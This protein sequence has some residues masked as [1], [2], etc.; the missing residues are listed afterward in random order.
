GNDTLTGGAGNDTFITSAGTDTIT[1]FASGDVVSLS[2]RHDL[3][4]QTIQDGMTTDGTNVTVDLGGG[5]TLVFADPDHALTHEDFGIAENGG[6]NT[7]IGGTGD[8]TL[9]G[10]TGNDTL[11]GAGG[12]DTLIGGDGTD[13]ADYADAAGGVTVDLSQTGGQTVGG[14][15]GIDTLSGIENLVGGSGN[16][17]LSGDANGNLLTG[18]DG[19]DTLSGGGGNDTLVSGAGYDIVDGGD[20]TDIA[21]FTGNAADYDVSIDGMTVMVK[22]GRGAA[23]LTDIETIRFDDAD[24]DVITRNL[25][26]GTGT[27]SMANT[28]SA[29]AVYNSRVAGLADGN[30]VVIWQDSYANNAADI[31]ARIF[32][33]DGNPQGSEFVVHVNGSHRENFPEITA[34]ENGGF[35]VAWRSSSTSDGDAVYSRSFDAS[36]SAT[37]ADILLHSATFSNSPSDLKLA[38]ASDGGY[39]VSY[40]RYPNTEIKKVTAAGSVSGFETNNGEFNADIALLENGNLAVVAFKS[41]SSGGS[42]T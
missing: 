19:H 38:A 5:D 9:D 21:V 20:G 41:Q 18:A 6:D 34:L 37:S 2:D 35:A 29:A 25:A 28:T 17:R 39:F 7:F 10:G 13:T 8:D 23:T 32:D 11:R 15:L 26:D 22:G 40:R 12:N 30:Y 31:K 14:G 42:Y 16:D 24:Y 1:D 36:G 33:T 27:T 4:W 3:N